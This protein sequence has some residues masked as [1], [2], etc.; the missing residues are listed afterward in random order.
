[1]TNLHIDP[2]F[3]L[4]H[5]LFLPFLLFAFELLLRDHLSALFRPCCAVRA[6]AL[7]CL[8]LQR[9]EADLEVQSRVSEKVEQEKS[10]RREMA[11]WVGERERER[12]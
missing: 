2:K 11:N 5:L 6:N 1:M 4:T 3:S 8:V 12:E 10:F 7:R 9:M